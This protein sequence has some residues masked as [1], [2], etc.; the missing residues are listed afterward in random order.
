MAQFQSLDEIKEE[1]DASGSKRGFK[2]QTSYH[3]QKSLLEMKK[4]RRTGTKQTK[5][6]FLREQVGN[7]IDSTVREYLLPPETQLLHKVV[8]FADHTLQDHFIAAPRMAL[9][10]ALNNPY[11]YLK[12]EA[13]KSE[14][15]IPNVT[16]D[17]CIALNCTSSAA[18]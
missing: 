13:L 15:C 12:N 7:F 11:Y 3:L 1:E 16:P 17:I 5:L 10:T 6:E 9:H 8:Y 18:G 14:G 2:R 4:L